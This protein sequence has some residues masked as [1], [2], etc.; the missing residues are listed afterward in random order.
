MSLI[1]IGAVPEEEKEMRISGYVGLVHFALR[2]EIRIGSAEYAPDFIGIHCHHF[3]P[4]GFVGLRTSF[5]GRGFADG[6]GFLVW[7]LIIFSSFL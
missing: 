7:Y 6:L 4:A 3:F 5:F 2:S 1:E